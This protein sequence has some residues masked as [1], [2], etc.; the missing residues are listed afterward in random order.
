MKGSKLSVRRSEVVWNLFTI[1]LDSD[2]IMKK[3]TIILLSVLL[4]LTPGQV[5]VNNIEI[6]EEKLDDTDSESGGNKNHFFL[7]TQLSLHH[8]FILII[9]YKN[10]NCVAFLPFVSC[11]FQAETSLSYQ[12]WLAS[13]SAWSATSARPWPRTNCSWSSGTRSAFPPPSTRELQLHTEHNS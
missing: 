12:A 11:H 8:L 7:S 3:Q 1:K 2:F 5:D 9:L 6:P 13:P 10:L 4:Q